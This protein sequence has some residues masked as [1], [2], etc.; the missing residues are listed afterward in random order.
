MDEY[1]REWKSLYD[2][3]K[4]IVLKKR[5]LESVLREIRSKV[6]D[7]ELRENV[8]VGVIDIIDKALKNPND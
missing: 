7:F 3:Y 2:N 8:V 6:D 4:T 5:S 1:E